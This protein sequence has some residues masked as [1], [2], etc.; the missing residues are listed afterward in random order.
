MRRL[1]WAGL[2]L[3]LLAGCKPKVPKDIL[4][5]EMMVPVLYDMHIADGYISTIPVPD[6]ARRVATSYYK[7]I[8]KKY[9]IDSAR[10]TKSMNYYYDHVDILSE[11]YKDVTADLKKSKDSVDKIQA[12]LLKKEEA[13]KK[14]KKDSADKANPKLVIA[15]ADSLRKVKKDSLEKVKLDTKAKALAVKKAKRDSAEKARPT[16]I[17]KAAAPKKVI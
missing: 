10:Y 15:R 17:N 7:A 3:I 13:A 9:G 2:V 16:S 1:Y 4:Q 11:M 5:P 14:L 12:K 6:S 8:Y